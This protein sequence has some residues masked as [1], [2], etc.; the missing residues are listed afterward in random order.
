MDINLLQVAINSFKQDLF[1][2]IT[3]AEYDNK[4]YPNGQKAKEALIRSQNLI[5]KIHDS[6]KESFYAKLKKDT[7]FDWKVYPPIGEKSPELKIYGKLKGKDQDLVFLRNEFKPEI[8]KEGPNSGE[9][10]TVGVE[11]IKNS[12]VIGVRS[13][14]SSVDKNFDT[15]MERAFAET[16]NLRLRVPALCMGE[17][18]VLPLIELDDQAMLKNEI[19]FFRRSVN[20]PKFIKTF[21]AFSGRKDL[22]IEEQY[23]Y[24]ASALVLIDLQTE[25]PTIVR[26]GDDLKKYNFDDET[27]EL[28]NNI[29][30]DGFDNRLS[31]SYLNFSQ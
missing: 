16:L 7:S 27:C 5:I 10:D 26:N 28:F 13:Q 9:V 18:Y 2:A 15:L 17:V 1:K 24:D 20:I 19:A 4:Q 8:I 29:S 12:I 30:P 11:A 22:S 3:T 14:M 6:T 25:N 23:K 31:K 21:N